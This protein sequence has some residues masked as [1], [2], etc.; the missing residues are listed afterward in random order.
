MSEVMV[1]CPKCA[2]QLTVSRTMGESQF[3][4]G[5]CGQLIK[6]AAMPAT[7]APSQPSPFESLPPSAPAN[8]QPAP[9][10][11]AA[12]P[13]FHSP[14]SAPR[15]ARR[16][17]SSGN[18]K[19]VVAAISIVLGIGLLGGI[20]YL[21]VQMLP[22]GS[23][24]K[25][26]PIGDSP[27]SVIGGLR[28]VVNKMATEFESIDDEASRD[29]AVENLKDLVDQARDLQ[30]RAVRLGTVPEDERVALYQRYRNE[31]P[32]VRDRVK[33]A[34]KRVRDRNL[35]NNALMEASVTI[36]FAIADVGMAIDAGWK[37]LPEPKSKWEE[38]EFEKTK[39]DRDTWRALLCVTSDSD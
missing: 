21:V 20:G 33:A 7:P 9:L 12:Q 29:A 24:A 30:K 10:P 14:V 36:G 38:L 31:I 27:S 8:T 23:L 13:T 34:A 18:G 39:L 6:L 19:I 26:N 5:N 37:A 15:P 32:P 17:Q 3:Q 28:D 2:S 16:R 1:Q 11:P 25:L 35:G 22:V 4:C